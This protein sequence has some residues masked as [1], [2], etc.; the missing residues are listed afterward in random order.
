MS[1]YYVCWQDNCLSIADESVVI[2]AVIVIVV[3]VVG[4]VDVIAGV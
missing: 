3:G 2:V 4:V 1:M